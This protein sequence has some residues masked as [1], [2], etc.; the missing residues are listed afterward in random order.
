[1]ITRTTDAA[2]IN[3]VLNDEAVRPWVADLGE[4]EIDI[5][6]IVE[7]P[8]NVCL[9]GEHGAF[10][11]L[12]FFE[13]IYEVHSAVLSA[14]RGE[15]AR[16][17]AHAGAHYMFTATDAVEILTRVPEG[18][19]AAAALI[20]SMGFTPQFKTPPE[21]RFRG[22]LVP[23]SVYTLTLQ[24]WS[25]KLAGPLA[26][27]GRRLHEWMN[28]Q[29]DGEPHAEDPDH[30]RIVGITFDMFKAGRAAK[31]TVFYNRWA[32]AAR[33]P[34]ITLLSVDPPRIKFDAGELSIVDGQL[35]LA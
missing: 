34:P 24:D 5:T 23:V 21:C 15:W 19:V 6:P 29:I 30:N 17:F 35:C 20:Y 10:V 4:G 31:A 8:A 3:S 12:K 2:F 26:E 33:H 13:G 32:Y 9:V 16:R 7:N 14:G 27:K 11:C 28:S 22:K 18:H 1:M 25:V